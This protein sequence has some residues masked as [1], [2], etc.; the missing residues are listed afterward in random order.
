MSS[1]DCGFNLMLSKREREKCGSFALRDDSGPLPG[2]AREG[3]L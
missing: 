2:M 1:A 3:E